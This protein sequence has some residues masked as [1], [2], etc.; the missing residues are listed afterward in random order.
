MG[1]LHLTFDWHYIGWTKVRLGFPKILWPS[2]SIWTL[3]RTSTYILDTNNFFNLSRLLKLSFI[4]TGYFSFELNQNVTNNCHLIENTYWKTTL[5]NSIIR[6]NKFIVWSF[7]LINLQTDKKNRTR[8]IANY[9]LRLLNLKVI[10]GW[11]SI[12]Y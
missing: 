4:K 6:N 1:Y 8:N 12:H 10:N 2:Q 9:H 7:Y 3:L 5:H 11:I